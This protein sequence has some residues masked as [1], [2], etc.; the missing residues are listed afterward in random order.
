[1]SASC[2]EALHSARR[3]CVD[4]TPE[5]VARHGVFVDA[6]DAPCGF[7]AATRCVVSGN[8]EAYYVCI[9]HSPSVASAAQVAV[10]VNG[11]PIAGV[12]SRLQLGVDATE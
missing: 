2:A 11:M 6:T 7:A 3:A 4:A 9:E 12:P 10:V 1:M 5:C 8:T